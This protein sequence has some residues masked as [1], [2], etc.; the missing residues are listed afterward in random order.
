MIPGAGRLSDHEREL[1]ARVQRVVAIEPNT[2][3][4]KVLRPGS[5]ERYLRREV[6]PG[7]WGQ[8]PPFDYRLV[9]GSVVRQQDCVALR[10]PADFVRALRL[11]FP[12][13]PF[14][15]DQPVLHTM[16]FPAV[17]PAQYV[18]PF[19]APSQPYPEQGF[20]PDHADVQLVAVAMAQA[21][22]RAG[23]DPNTFR[24]EIRPW[25]YTGTGLTA[26][27]NT[28]VPERWR[29]YGPIPAGAVLVE[30]PARRPVAGYR[31]EARGWEVTR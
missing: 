2:A 20:P 6:S 29:R 5:V 9:G 27:P 1:V 12:L 15:P 14:R 23:V 25:P 13:S 19:G 22:E 24:R 17:D 31:G 18:T 3:M 10:T 26:E 30:Y 8:A 7:V 16:E 4:L 11:D 21:A 28:G